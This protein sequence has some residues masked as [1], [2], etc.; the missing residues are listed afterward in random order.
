MKKLPEAEEYVKEFEYFPWGDLIKEILDILEK[1][2]PKNAKIL[3]LMCGPGYLL[4]K[5]NKK[6]SDLKMIGVDIDGGFIRDAQKKY[7]NIK[8]EKEDVLKWQTDEKFDAIVCTGGVHHLKYK[9]QEEFIRKIA[10]LLNKNGFC[11]IADPYIENYKSEKERKLRALK[12]G[13]E[14]LKVVIK[15]DAPNELIAAAIDI[16]FNDLMGFEY[17]TSMKKMLPIFKKFFSRIEKH[18]I[19]PKKKTKYGDYYFIL[20]L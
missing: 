18:K 15:K 5:L 3:D 14:Y 2:L 10:S 8:F 16:K 9:N 17:K 12:L 6:R 1:K 11:I 4:G 7:P 20:R 13:S 19:W